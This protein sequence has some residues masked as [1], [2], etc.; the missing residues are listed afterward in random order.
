MGS[1]VSQYENPVKLRVSFTA[2]ETAFIVLQ[3]PAL[4]AY[5]EYMASGADE[6]HEYFMEML[7]DQL[8]DHI[9]QWTLI[10]DWDHA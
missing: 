4:D 6:D 5:Y 8:E 7:T 9:A 3:G 10:D 1:T 2:P